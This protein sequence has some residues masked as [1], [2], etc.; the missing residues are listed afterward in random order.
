MLGNSDVEST[1]SALLSLEG[2]EM[3]WIVSSISVYLRTVLG[4]VWCVERITLQTLRFAEDWQ[5]FLLQIHQIFPC[6]INGPDF[7]QRKEW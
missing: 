1:E 3:S 5:D 7:N 2:L 6:D 4:G